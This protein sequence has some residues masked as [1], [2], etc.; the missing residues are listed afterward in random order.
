MPSLAENLRPLTDGAAPRVTL[1]DIVQRV[2]ASGGLAPVLL[3][4]TL[5]VL[6]PLPPGFSMVLA[7]PLLLAA[8]QMVAGRRDLWLPQGLARQSIARDRLKKGFVRILPWVDRLE[9]LARPRLTF[10]TGRM[11]GVLAGAGCTA[12][13]VVPVLPLPFANLLPA[14]TV[15]V[16]CL[17]LTRRDGALVLAGF[18]LLA[19]AV[20]G[21]AWGVHGAR[22]G[23]DWLRRVI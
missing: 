6:L 17:G 12:M 8:P 22:L 11:G 4:L 1:H 23:V 3:V 21:A 5:P 9:G 2:E 14:L 18:A 10:L 19:A 16:L 20:V 15:C 7:L 13:A